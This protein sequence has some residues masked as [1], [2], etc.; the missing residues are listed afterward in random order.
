MSGVALSIATTLFT[1]IWHYVVARLL[2]DELI[3]PLADGRLY[4]LVPLA[5][6]V[7]V[8]ALAA[9]TLR[10]ARSRRSR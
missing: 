5:A 9:R 1:Y 7:V 2:Y 6:L 4:A 3:R 10:R 8:V